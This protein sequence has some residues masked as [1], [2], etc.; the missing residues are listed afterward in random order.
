MTAIKK[1]ICSDLPNKLK[2]EA[3]DPSE[4]QNK[5]K[6]PIDLEIL[7]SGDKL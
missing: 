1:Q 3:S 4:T 5:R 6:N 2:M 7:I